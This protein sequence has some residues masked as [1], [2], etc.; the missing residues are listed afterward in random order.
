MG[1]VSRV[2]SMVTRVTEG[3]ERP[4]PWYLPISG[5]WLAADSPWNWWQ[6]GRNVE[7]LEHGAMVEACV[8]AYSQT[9]AQCPGDHWLSTDDGGR[10]RCTTSSLSRILREPNAYQTISDFMLNAVRSLYLT[11][12]AYALALRNSRYEIVELH[13]M[14]ARA[15]AAMVSEN[16]DIF[17]SLGGNSVIAQQVA[18]YG[19][20]PYIM[21]P[22]RDVLHIRLH[23]SPYNTLRG[24]TPLMAA[25]RDMAFAD[26]ALQQQVAFYLNQARPSAVLATE[27]VLDKDQV[28]FLRERWNEQSR[29]LGAGGTPILTAGLKPVPLATVPKDAELAELLKM[30]SQNIALAFRIP[31]QI[32]GIGTGAIGSTEALM[33][34]WISGGLGFCLN[35]V[36]EAFDHTFGLAG[37]PDEYVEFNTAALLRSAFKERIESLARAVQGG[38]LSPNEARA[39]EDYKAVKDGDEPRVQQQ[40][41]PLS[42][43]S[44]GQ[45]PPAPGQHSAGPAPPS[46]APIPA[47]PTAALA[48]K[49]ARGFSTDDEHRLRNQFDRSRRISVS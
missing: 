7:G 47:P 8:S 45:I 18:E 29:R 37:E 40:V 24:E 42:F 10:K 22:A 12:N 46:A 13:L 6:L 9:V 38:I 27:Q 21:V 14:N 32:L 3:D 20:T 16:G 26:A 2:K 17:Y 49:A 19:G 39:T 34:S 15:C 48:S 33:Q 43:A 41:V 28:N 4:G 44:A 1:L 23:T 36:E 25:T 30:S 5:G 11:G 31:Q 35:H